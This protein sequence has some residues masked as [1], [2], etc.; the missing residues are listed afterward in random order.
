MAGKLSAV[1]DCM[2]YLQALLRPRGPAGECVER[3]FKDEVAVF[4]SDYVLEEIDDVARRPSIVAR[5]GLT[6][7]LI[8][9][10]LDSLL[11]HVIWQEAP[12]PV[13][14]LSSDRDDEH[15]LNLAIATA[16]RYVVSRDKHLLRLMDLGHVESQKF[17]AAHPNIEIVTPPQFL[18]EL[19]QQL[20]RDD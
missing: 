7:G 18:F 3:L 2:V 6:P 19:R 20:K 5:F 13:V 10:F 12:P 8:D 17:R 11:A 1:Y 4:A 16:S 14:T 15:Y 9:D